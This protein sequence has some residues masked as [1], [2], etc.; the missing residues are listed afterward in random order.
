MVWLRRQEKEKNDTCQECLQEA[1]EKNIP[2]IKR[3]KYVEKYPCS[4]HGHPGFLPPKLI[5]W[6][7]FFFVIQP[8]CTPQTLDHV[9]IS[10]ICDDYEIPFSK[11]FEMLTIILKAM[12]KPDEHSDQNKRIQGSTEVPE[13]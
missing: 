11:A 1:I 5:A 4:K 7:E 13:G 10:Q 3:I 12:T 9:L 2:A 8:Y 6:V